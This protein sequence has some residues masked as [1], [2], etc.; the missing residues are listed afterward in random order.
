MLVHAFLLECI[1]VHAYDFLESFSGSMYQ[2][3]GDH[4]IT[5]GSPPIE[6]DVWNYDLSGIKENKTNDLRTPNDYTAR[7]RAFYILSSRIYQV[8][9][10]I[11]ILAVSIDHLREQSI[12]LRGYAE[13]LLKKGYVGHNAPEIE[14]AELR[15]AQSNA[16]WYIR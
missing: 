3:V 5:G 2:W 8:V 7:S 4:Y 12:F 6:N 1:V 13:E 9:T 11:D 16:G 15:M 14:I 10:D